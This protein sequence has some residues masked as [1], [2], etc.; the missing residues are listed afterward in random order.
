MY[1][2]FQSFLA[3]YR[4]NVGISGAYI[5]A[6]SDLQKKGPEECHK[7]CQ[8]M[9]GCVWFTWQ[10]KML[11]NLGSCKL[12]SIIKEFFSNSSTEGIISGPAKCRGKFKHDL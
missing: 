5:N 6:H 12:L 7:L 1:F 8:N 4:M 11:Q 3:C 10:K 2:I 9:I